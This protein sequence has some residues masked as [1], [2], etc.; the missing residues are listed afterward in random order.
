MV[1]RNI[2]LGGKL[3]IAFGSITL[4]LFIV[5]VWAIYGVVGILSDANKM[6]KGNELRAELEERYVQH[7]IWTNELS[8][9]INDESIGEFGLETEYDKNDFGRW[10][11]GEGR[12]N[13]EQ[14]SPKMK[15]L[16]A[17]FEEPHKKL[18]ETANQ[19]KNLIKTEKYFDEDSIEWVRKFNTKEAN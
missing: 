17:E 14:Y 6:V 19:I 15:E 9:Y 18:L 8:R 13:A 10:Y 4:I 1:W 5:G 16:L 12:K 3:G 11:Y 2:K 7:L